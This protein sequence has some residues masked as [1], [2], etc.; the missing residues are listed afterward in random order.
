MHLQKCDINLEEITT[1]HAERHFVSDSTELVSVVKG[2]EK[3]VNSTT[4]QN[5][6]SA[7]N[8]DTHAT[9]AEQKATLLRCRNS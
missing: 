7:A 3:L 4:A 2:L 6:S 8:F 9:F 5:A 1:L